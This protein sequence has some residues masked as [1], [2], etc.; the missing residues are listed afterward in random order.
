MI[1]KLKKNELNGNKEEEIEY[2]RWKNYRKR[3]QR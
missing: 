1:S 2:K 3:K